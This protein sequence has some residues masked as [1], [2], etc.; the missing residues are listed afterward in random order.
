MPPKKR[1]LTVPFE[2]IHAD[3]DFNCRKDY[4]DID[5]LKQSILDD[6][7][8]Q[9]VGVALK[10]ATDDESPKYFL[11]YGFRRYMALTKIR[12]ELGLDAYA[13]LD[14]VVNEGNLEDLRVRNLKENIER[15]SLS[16]FE[17]AQQVKRLV[18]AGLEQ[19]EIAVRL[20]RNQSWVSYHYKVATQLSS[21]AQSA[22]KAKDIT[23]EQALHIADVP[24]EQQNELVNQIMG[25]DTRAD[26]RQL[27]KEAA[28]E[29]GKR[30]KYANKGRPTAKNLV[31]WVSD[32]SYEAESQVS[33]KTEK[34]FYNG[35][36]A[37]LRAALGDFDLKDLGA[38]SKY[39][40]VN[41]HARNNKQDDASAEAHD[42]AEV[43][44]EKPAAKKRGRPR[45]NATVSDS[46]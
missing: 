39:A 28:S 15:K 45:K 7:L 36:V 5:V 4:T 30:R 34:T 40:D 32:A 24:E 16:A 42:G 38:G 21:Q 22:L 33:D 8:L 17:I 20:G 44:V 6:G 12:E 10:T 1:M 18:L 2:A 35:V 29:S 13:T 14:V 25:A 11:V 3:I 41:Y 26:A 43:A 31:Q 23:L 27:L 19:R 37:G 46:I 9:P